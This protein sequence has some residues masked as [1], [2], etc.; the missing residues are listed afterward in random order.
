MSEKIYTPEQ[1]GKILQIHP[2]TVLRYIK[3]KKIRASKLGRVYR[4]TEG[5]LSEFL[6]KQSHF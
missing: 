3:E 2:F 1:V 4:I 6:E 5:A